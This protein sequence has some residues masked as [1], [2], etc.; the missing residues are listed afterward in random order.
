MRQVCYGVAMSLDGY[1]AGPNGELDWIVVDPEIDFAAIY[2][3][4]DTLLMGRAT[5]EDAMRRGGMG[6]MPGMQAVVVSRTL[7]PQDYPGITILSENVEEAV[8]GLRL[9][10]GKD[11]WLFGGGSLFRSLLGA[12]LVDRVELTVIPVLLGGGVPLFPAPAQPAKL[13]LTGHKVYPKTGTVSL[14]YAMK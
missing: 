6:L 12:G 10:P 2:S 7:R 3:R 5:F 14:E 9:K 1:I 4:F 13:H 8:N 11:I